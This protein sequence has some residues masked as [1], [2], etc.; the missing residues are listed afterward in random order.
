M[1]R[2]PTVL[3]MSRGMRIHHIYREMAADLAVDHRVVVLAAPEEVRSFAALGNVEVRT[4]RTSDIPSVRTNGHA[5]PIAELR[6]RAAAIEQTIGLP[7]YKAA[8]NYLLYGRIVKSFGGHWAY[9]DREEE[10]LRAYVGAYEDLAALFDEV[11]PD[12]VFYDTIDLI[13]NFVAFV[14]AL[15]RG[16][17]A[18]DFRFSPFSNGKISVGFGLYRKNVVMEYLYDHPEAIQPESYAAAEDIL[19]RP[20]EYL[21]GTSY[22]TV[23]LKMFASNRFLSPQ[24]LAALLADRRRLAHSMKNVRWYVRGQCNRLWLARHLVTDPPEEPYLVFFLPHLPEASTCS[25]SPRWV[26]PEAVV[27]QLAINAPSH[28]KIVVKEH[29]RTYGRRGQAF[30]KPLQALPNVVTC[31]PLTDNYRLVAGAEAVVA[32]TG[33]IGFEGLLLGKRVGILGR[34]FYAAYRGLKQLNYPEDIYQ[35]LDDP[36]YRPETMGEERRQFLAAYVQSLHEFGYGEGTAIYPKTGGEKWAAALRQTMAFIERYGLV[37]TQ[38]DT[39]LPCCTGASS[40][41]AGVRDEGA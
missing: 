40:A 8:S 6:E 33:T 7:L 24:K 19:A 34:P 23:N 16:V 15:R 31:H 30:F 38:F 29:P 20:R 39:G 41:A 14:L 22:A 17:F 11:E 5:M 12:L 2:R 1:S 18:V 26:Y 4:Y 21:Y 3:I 27:E 35:A 36:S 10:I 25:Q 32:V 13:S 9:L 28:L 37:P